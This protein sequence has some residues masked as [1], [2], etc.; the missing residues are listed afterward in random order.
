MVYSAFILAPYLNIALAFGVLIITR[1]TFS[2]I[3]RPKRPEGLLNAQ[4]DMDRR[5]LTEVRSHAP[6]CATLPDSFAHSGAWLRSLRQSLLRTK[7]S[8]CAVKRTIYMSYV[9]LLY[10]TYNSE[11]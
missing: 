8:I 9:S 3:Q 1:L 10:G 11:T 2:G 7:A 6:E 5:T 4:E